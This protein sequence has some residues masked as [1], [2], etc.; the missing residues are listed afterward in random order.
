MRIRS[1]FRRVVSIQTVSLKRT[2]ETANFVAARS[3]SVHSAQTTP[4][5]LAEVH[6]SRRRNK[7]ALARAR[8]VAM[9]R[10]EM[11][12]AELPRV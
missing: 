6:H 4:S 9:P 7:S 12:S 2:E 1:L 11:K 5:M 10:D 8:E 3:A